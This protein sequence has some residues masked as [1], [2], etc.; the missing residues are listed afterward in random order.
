MTDTDP[1]A[2]TSDVVVPGGMTMHLIDTDTVPEAYRVFWTRISDNG[3]EAAR[4]KSFGVLHV[5]SSR[6]LLHPA[7][8]DGRAHAARVAGQANLLANLAAQLNLT[9]RID[10]PPSPTGRL[11]P[12]A[13]EL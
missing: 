7:D 8:S 1:D 3:P 12:V 10:V 5:P 9:V 6:V 13:R 11:T 2:P 4:W